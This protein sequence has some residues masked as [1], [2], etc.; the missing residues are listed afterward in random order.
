VTAPISARLT[1]E[2]DFAGRKK[3]NVGVADDAIH[4]SA[5]TI[6]ASATGGSF[7]ATPLC[8]GCRSGRFK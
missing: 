4:M 6:T 2:M 1:D 5:A 7:N 3:S 8:G